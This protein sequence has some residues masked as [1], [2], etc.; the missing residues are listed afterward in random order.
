MKIKDILTLINDPKVYIEIKYTPESGGGSFGF[1]T[2]DE[3]H[4][5]DDLK[6]RKIEKINVQYFNNKRLLVLEVL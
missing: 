3:L 4:Y 2:K 5:N 1:F 6:N